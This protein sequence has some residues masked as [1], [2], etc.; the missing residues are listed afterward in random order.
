[1]TDHGNP[2]VTRPTLRNP[3]DG[4]LGTE[5]QD[6]G[7]SPSSAFGSRLSVKGLSPLHTGM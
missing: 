6:L 1:M 5:G 4:L 3:W 2:G 7:Q